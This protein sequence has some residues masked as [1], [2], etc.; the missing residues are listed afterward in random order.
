MKLEIVN[1]FKHE[2]H[3]ATE[4]IYGD[5]RHS[6]SKMHLICVIACI[7]ADG[8]NARAVYEVELRGESH[9][10]PHSSLKHS[11]RSRSYFAHIQ[12]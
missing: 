7:A 4:T 9:V 3:F 6:K 10:L 11:C 8:N 12:R 2:P 1:A 5:A